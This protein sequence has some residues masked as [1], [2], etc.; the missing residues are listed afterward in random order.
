MKE[1]FEFVV[2]NSTYVKINYTELDEFINN[3]GELNYKHWSKEVNLNLTEKEW[4][5][6]AFLIESM[7]FCFWIKPKWKIEYHNDI[8]SGS[9]ALFYSAI[10]EVE[11]NKNF[12][13]YEQFY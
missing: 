10:K 1:K 12:I 6:L 7:N 11:N 4:I 2:D 5:I 8:L 3:L 9:N 13:S